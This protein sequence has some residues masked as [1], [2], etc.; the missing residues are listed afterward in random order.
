M[1][2]LQKISAYIPFDTDVVNT[3][4]NDRILKLSVTNGEG[5]VGIDS[6]FQ[7]NYRPIE[8]VRKNN[9]L[10]LILRS[11]DTFVKENPSEVLLISAIKNGTLL[12]HFSYDFVTFLISHGYDVFDLIGSGDA[13]DKDT[14]TID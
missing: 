11:M 7:K 2:T 8:I 3:G 5:C 10:K 12:Q 6:F 13:V 1:T 4:Y 9:Y 14:L